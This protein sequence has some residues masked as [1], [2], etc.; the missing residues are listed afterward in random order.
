M[1]TTIS[2][3]VMMVVPWV[4]LLVVIVVAT[5]MIY[6]LKTAKKGIHFCSIYMY[7]AEPFY[8]QQLIT[9]TWLI[10]EERKNVCMTK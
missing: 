6:W 8:Y 4:L 2:T 1:F 5:G 9:Q 10:K 7:Q 3:V